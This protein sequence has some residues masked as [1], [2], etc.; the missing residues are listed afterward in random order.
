MFVITPAIEDNNGIS[1]MRLGEGDARIT[2]SFDDR[3][4]EHAPIDLMFDRHVK[5]SD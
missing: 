1:A 3:P 2:I 4:I 5:M